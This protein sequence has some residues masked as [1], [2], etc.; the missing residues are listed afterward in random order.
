MNKSAGTLGI[1]TYL[2]V[3]LK[4]VGSTHAANIPTGK[5]F[6]L[7]QPSKVELKLDADTFVENKFGGIDEIGVFLK[8]E[9]KLEADTFV[10]NKF[11]GIDNTPV[12]PKVLS[13]LKARV[14]FENGVLGMVSRFAQFENA[15]LKFDADTH[16]LNRLL[17]KVSIFVLLNTPLK[18]NAEMQ[19]LN[20]FP[21]IVV[22]A[23]QLSNV[24]M[25]S[26]A[27]IQFENKSS[28]IEVKLTQL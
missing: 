6:T 28:G 24:P 27:D 14:L 15:K 19:L 11:V 10:E 20:K 25:N 2:N 26:N 21:G 9:L 16:G 23:L 12:S 18:F 17:E 7:L 3:E 22:K 8:V 5:T 4:L 13:K 1:G